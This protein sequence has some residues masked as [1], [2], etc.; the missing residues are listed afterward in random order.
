NPAEK[1]AG[2][3]YYSSAAILWGLGLPFLILFL[4]YLLLSPD[5][6]LG[7][8]IMSLIF[9]LPVWVWAGIGVFLFGCHRRHY[10]FGMEKDHAVWMWLLTAGFNAIQATFILNFLDGYVLGNAV[11][12]WNLIVASLS[13]FAFY[14]E[15]KRA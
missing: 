7:L 11:G 9:G 8:L 12:G 6:T 3:F 15:M 10:K 2:L 1:I 5:V 4:V 13:L 14:F